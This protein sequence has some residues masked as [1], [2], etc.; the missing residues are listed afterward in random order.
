MKTYDRVEF[1]STG[2]TDLDGKTGRILGIASEH[3]TNN[4]WIVLLD[5]PLPEREAVVII[6]ACI[7]L[8]GD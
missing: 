1:H 2:S 4:F 3:A 6:D 5:V 8:I 7:K